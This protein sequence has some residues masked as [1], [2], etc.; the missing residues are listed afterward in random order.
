MILKI[1]LRL[2]NLQFYRL[3]AKFTAAAPVIHVAKLRQT[4]EEAAQ[5]EKLLGCKGTV[6]GRLFADPPTTTDWSNLLLKDH[7]QVPLPH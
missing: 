5:Q 7:S 3:Q 4:D 1:P 2:N 6:T